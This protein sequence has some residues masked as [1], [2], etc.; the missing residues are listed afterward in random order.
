V[1]ACAT[2][3]EGFRQ[4]LFKWLL[5]L[6]PLQGTHSIREIMDINRLLEV[7]EHEIE[8]EDEETVVDRS[9]G[10]DGGR[11]RGIIAQKQKDHAVMQSPLEQEFLKLSGW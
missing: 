10:A 2:G 9:M 6:S 7:I 11:L 5:C 4:T 8:E 3:E 1:S